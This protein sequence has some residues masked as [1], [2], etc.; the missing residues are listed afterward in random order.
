MK[1][2]IT[3][4]DTAVVI[5]ELNELISDA[6]VTNI[7]QTGFK[8]L[9]LKLH[10]AD[11][12]TS[13]LLIKAGNRLH[14]TTLALEKPSKP[15]AFCMTLRKHLR[16]GRLKSIEQHEFERIVIIK[17]KAKQ[18]EFQL[19]SELFSDGNIILVNSNR[20]LQALSYKKMRDRNILRNE[21]FQ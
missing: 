9:I 15:S 13:N 1:K 21:T 10:Q 11:R 8:T 4:V 16:N 5:S 19:I 12:P 2:E 6:W 20:I 18:T 17:I 7:Y 3:S 14:L